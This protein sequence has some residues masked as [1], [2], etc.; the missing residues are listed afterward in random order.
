MINKDLKQVVKL[1][2][3]CIGSNKGRINAWNI[4]RHDNFSISSPTTLGLFTVS[5][6]LLSLILKHL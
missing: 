6:L 5:Y 3:Q 4:M 2:N 1:C